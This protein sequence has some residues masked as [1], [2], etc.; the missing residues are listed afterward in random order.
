[1]ALPSPPPA[2]QRGDRA[3]FS[4]RVDAFLNWLVT[5]IP[6]LNTMLSSFTV[7][8]AGGAN[9]FAYTF[10]TSTADTD[11]GNGKLRLGSST[12]NTAVMLR[13][14]NSDGTGADMSGF[15][16]TLASGTSNIKGSVRLQKVNDANAW[17]LFD[18]TSMTVGAGYRNLTVIPRAS[19][20]ANP[21]AN[22]DTLMVFFDK[23]GDK[24]DGG[25]TP[26]AQQIRDA[27]GTLGEANGGTGATT[28]AQARINLSLDKVSN[29]SDANKPV[30]TAQQTA[31]DTKLNRAGGTMSG[32][33]VFNNGLGVFG[34]D[35]ANSTRAMVGY[36]SDNNVFQYTGTGGYLLWYN[37]SN[38]NIASL[39]S[40]GAFVAQSVSGTSDETLKEN[41]RFLPDDFLEQYAAI[42]NAELFDWRDDG[43][44]DG[45]IGAQSIQKIAPWAV[46]NVFGILR[47]NYSALNAAVLHCLTRRVLR[48][49]GA[50]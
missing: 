37:P 47:V 42:E 22:N 11:P 24:G 50:K 49:E 12:Q 40:G 23:N 41:W 33:L 45:G 31:L 29:T 34:T 15:L 43:R 16:S 27:V 6:A 38:A 26:T 35:T 2:P 44:T 48:N 9:S 3:T 30:S 17:I 21:F 39:S 7:L 5:L 18:I 28:F 13:L 46:T 10:D 19:S 14:D 4:Q 8:A 25:G 36:G 1:M 32:S 20:S